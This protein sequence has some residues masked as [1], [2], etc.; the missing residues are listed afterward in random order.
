MLKASAGI[1]ALAL[2]I[3]AAQSPTSVEVSRFADK[4]DSAVLAGV[5][6]GRTQSVI[7]LGKRQL[8]APIGGLT[9]FA[10]RNA[11]ADRRVLRKQVID[12]L[13][14]IAS[15]E[16]RTIL[17]ALKRE[18][19]E[20]SLWIVNAFVARLSVAE[21]RAAAELDA[22][23]FI[24]PGPDRV[25][26]PRARD[27]AAPNEKP[28]S[29]KPFS[30]DGKRI[31]WNIDK[32]GGP[33]VWK[34]L[35]VTGDGIVVA[36]FDAGVNYRHHDLRAN[37]WRNA[38]EIPANGRDDDRN[39]YVDD[40]FGYDF[41][42]MSADILPRGTAQPQQ[43]G[44]VTSGIA[45]GD[46][47]D[48]IITGVAPRAHLMA[49]RAGGGFMNAALAFEYAIA[50]G[51]DIMSMSFSLADLGN[52]RGLWRM[53]SDHAVAA[54]LVPAGGAGNFR[55][56]ATIPYQ[57]QTPKDAPNV[58]SA[59]GVDSSL[60]IVRFSSG[61][62]AEW[63]TVAIYGDYPM[64]TGLIKPDVVG[65]PGPGYPILSATSDSG[66]LDPN[67]R[68]QGNSFSGPQAAGVAALVLSAAPST[69]AWRVHQILEATARDLGPPG[70][71][72]NFGSGLLD[73]FAAVQRARAE[74]R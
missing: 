2:M 15:A 28:V 18:R 25:P 61:G 52:T 32:L 30:T 14:A 68:V 24:Y 69:P 63:G 53:M 4:L 38:N 43:H 42:A 8:F 34:E 47:S 27:T 67:D 64:P 54:G 11:N 19:A 51:A 1:A 23:A 65:F 13:K 62:P 73:A 72:N 16:Q 21:V 10:Q 39:G 5:T 46:G 36:S 9:A 31:P 7:V 37:M 58:I 3:A 40:L 49:L 70:K 26:A 22:V 71:D 66:Y 35:G 74:H 57:H 6:A 60:R 48:G 12:S 55:M 41:T 20:R 33:R 17:G 50:N 29:R 45:V 44:T 56:S 59:G